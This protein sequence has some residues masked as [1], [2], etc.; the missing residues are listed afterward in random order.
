MAQTAWRSPAGTAKLA[1]T[2][3][4][5][6]WGIPRAR[7]SGAE[8]RGMRPQASPGTAE[9]VAAE[10]AY[11]ALV[12]SSKRAWR[13]MPSRKPVLTCPFTVTTSWGFGIWVRVKTTIVSR[14]C[15]R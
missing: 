2:D 14:P 6:K 8:P 7:R 12:T 4:R 3:R 1:R 9:G 5:V 15:T 11:C 13:G 10:S